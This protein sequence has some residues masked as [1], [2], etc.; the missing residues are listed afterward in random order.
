MGRYLEGGLQGSYNGHL[1]NFLFLGDI[2][3]GHR[4]I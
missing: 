2:D 1:K 4:A 3:I